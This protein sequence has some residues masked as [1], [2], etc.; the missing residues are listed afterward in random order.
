MPSASEEGGAL[1]VLLVIQRKI[2]EQFFELDL[3]R[4]MRTHS[5]DT[6]S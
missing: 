2:L 6:Q 4:N 5:S 1:I 3:Q